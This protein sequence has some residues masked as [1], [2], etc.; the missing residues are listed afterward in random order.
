[1]NKRYWK[2]FFT[3]PPFI[4]TFSIS[5]GFP[6]LIILVSLFPEWVFGGFGLLALSACIYATYKGADE[7]AKDMLDRHGNNKDD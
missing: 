3:S 2:Y 7:H 5:I 4:I 6:L 1:M